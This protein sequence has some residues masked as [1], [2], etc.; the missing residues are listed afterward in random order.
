MA[1]STATSPPSAVSPAPSG[2]SRNAIC[3]LWNSGA[4]GTAGRLEFLMEAHHYMAPPTPD[5]GKALVGR[6]AAVRLTTV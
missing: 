5:Q 3:E 4:E 6:L 2:L 1:I